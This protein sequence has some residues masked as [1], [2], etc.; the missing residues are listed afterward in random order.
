MPFKNTLLVGYWKLTRKVVISFL[1]V[2]LFKWKISSKL[3]ASNSEICFRE[4]FGNYRRTELAKP[5]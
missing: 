3:P 2:C 4:I 5:Q 1:F